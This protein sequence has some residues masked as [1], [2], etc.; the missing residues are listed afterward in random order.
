MLLDQIS[1]SGERLA[2]ILEPFGPAIHGTV[3]VE[4][5]Q[6]NA[7]K[8]KVHAARIFAGFLVAALTNRSL[9][10]ERAAPLKLPPEVLPRYSKRRA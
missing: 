6:A 10:L 8:V 4:L 7:D 2:A 9:Q 1:I 5:N 3:A